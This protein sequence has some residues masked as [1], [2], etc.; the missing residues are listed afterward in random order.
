VHIEDRMHVMKKEKSLKYFSEK[1]LYFFQK[2]FDI[3]ENL[4]DN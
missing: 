3:L 4:E 2:K 1:T